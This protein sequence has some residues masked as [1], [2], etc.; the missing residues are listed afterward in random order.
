MEN[1]KEMIEAIEKTDDPTMTN[2][3]KRLRVTIGTL[4]TAMNRLVEKGYVRRYREPEDKRKVMIA[5]TAEAIPVLEVHN[6]FHDEM[7]GTTIDDMRLDEDELLINA[8]MNIRDYFK[9]KY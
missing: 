7:I 8:L 3:S 9:N 2:L 1:H 5:L 6:Q 4:T